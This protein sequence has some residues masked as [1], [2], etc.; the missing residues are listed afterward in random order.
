MFKAVV[1]DWAGTMIDFG[2]FAPMGAFVETFVEFDIEVSVD[3]ARLPMGLP[4][5]HHIAAMLRQTAISARWKKKYGT[6]PTD[7]DVDK[8]YKVFLPKNE[9]VAAKSATLVPGA[10]NTVNYLRNK[11]L[12]IGSTTGYTRSIMN[13]VLPIAEAQGYVPDNLVCSDDLAEGRPGPLG[14]YKCFLDL[15]VYP[16]SAVIKVDDTEPGIGEG[17]AAGCVTVG[18]SISGNYVGR[19]PDEL[20]LLSMDELDELRNMST[21]KLRDAGADYVIDTV[22]DLPDLIERL[23]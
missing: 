14:M 22:A 10:V 3:E 21:E 17:A 19:T 4:K 11:G 13:H 16:P 15:G 12:K 9:E 8:L 5:W 18:V 6:Q 23:N 20:A 1:F 7:L 2:S